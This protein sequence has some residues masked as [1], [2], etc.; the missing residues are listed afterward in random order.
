MLMPNWTIWRPT[1]R[2]SRPTPGSRSYGFA[3]PHPDVL[4]VHPLQAIPATT[5]EDLHPLSC[6]R[7]HGREPRVVRGRRGR[8]VSVLARQKEANI[9]KNPLRQL[10]RAASLLLFILFLVP[11]P[12]ALNV[13]YA[14]PSPLHLF[15]SDCRA[16]QGGHTPPIV[17]SVRG[18]IA[19][20]GADGK[21]FCRLT[22]SV[23]RGTSPNGSPPGYGN[24]IG[25]ASNPRLSPTGREIAYLTTSTMRS[26]DVWIAPAAG[27]GDGPRRITTTSQTL[28]REG[29]SWSP[30]GRFLAYNEAP[31]TRSDSPPY[32]V[33]G[34]VVVDRI[35]GNRASTVMNITIRAK[36]VPN[37]YTFGGDGPTLA[38]SPDGK[39]IA[40]VV[41]FKPG[42]VYSSS[43]NISVADL[44][45]SRVHSI[46]VR[47]PKGSLTASQP[48]RAQFQPG[49]YA[50][51]YGPAWTPDGRHLI[52]TTFSRGAGGSL[53][54]LWRVS[55]RGG[56]AH[57]FVGT[58]SD[59]HQHVPASVPV[60]EATKFLFSPNRRLLVTDPDNRFWVADASG[61]HGAIINTNVPTSCRLAQYTWLSN[62]QGLAYVTACPVPGSGSIRLRLYSVQLRAT[63]HL[64]FGIVDKDQ[65]ALTLAPAGRCIACA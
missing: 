43:L 16:S 27:L 2:S 61:S 7:Y 34:T 41:G 37:T 64:L 42:A 52:V 49:S 15:T 17:L 32:F 44:A 35:T 56:V 38:W 55:E 13:G 18:S 50:T 46:V 4:A 6:M 21:N 48:R 10:T 39:K 31:P 1:V 54:G 3:R 8:R 11:V 40:T 5:S 25:A 36:G 28:D 20:I 26:H 12:G 51:G 14:A 47:F 19:T 30:G 57:L 33:G 45:T 60:N 24:T 58:P 62:N 63:S 53:T 9:I 65:N 23:A 22:P 29:L 59:V